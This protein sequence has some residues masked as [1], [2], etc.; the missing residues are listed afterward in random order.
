MRILFLTGGDPLCA[1]AFDLASARLPEHDWRSFVLDTPARREAF[2]RERVEGDLLISFLNP[3]V[4]PPE[5]LDRVRG[6]AYNV[7]PAPPTRPGNDSHAFAIYDGEHVAGATLHLMEASVDA[8]PIYAVVERQLG[9]ETGFARLR[10][11]SRHMALSLM[12]QHLEGLVGGTLQPNGRTWVTENR[13]TRADY[14]AMCRIEPSMDADELRRR[15]AAFHHPTHRNQPYV[16]LHGAVFVYDPERS[17][18]P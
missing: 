12:L 1:T 2:E 14:Q 11:L 4:V 9:P 15:I 3:Y 16:E 5:V 10:E 18:G 17:S 8:G 13:R 7:H 6:R